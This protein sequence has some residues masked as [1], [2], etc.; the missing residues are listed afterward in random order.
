MVPLAVDGSKV[1]GVLMQVPESLKAVALY[2]NGD[3]V[4][5]VGN[6]E[7]RGVLVAASG[8]V[9][10]L[11]QSITAGSEAMMASMPALCS[12]WPSRSP[13]GPAP[14]MAT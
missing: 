11:D 3:T 9:T 13:D 2:Y 8:P 6:A 7:G 12:N 14:M 4:T 5:T 1:D 10:A